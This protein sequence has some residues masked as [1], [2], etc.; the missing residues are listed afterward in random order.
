MNQPGIRP[1]PFQDHTSSTTERTDLV[2]LIEFIV[3]SVVVLAVILPLLPLPGVLSGKGSCAKTL[4]HRWHHC[5]AFLH[6]LTI[7]NSTVSTHI[8]FSMGILKCCQRAPVRVWGDPATRRYA[9][10]TYNFIHP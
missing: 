7:D 9:H 6:F 3:V 5:F 4:R 8:K 1:Y 2:I 10:Y